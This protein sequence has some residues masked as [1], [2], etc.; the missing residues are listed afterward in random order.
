LNY[1]SALNIDLKSAD[2]YS[3]LTGAT[4]PPLVADAGVTVGVEARELAGATHPADDDAVAE[5]PPEGVDC[6]LAS[7]CGDALPSAGRPLPCS[8][9]AIATC[10][11]EPK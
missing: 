8:K 3:G 1:P 2:R 4:H 9:V 10:V 7:S 11:F 6:I 5:D